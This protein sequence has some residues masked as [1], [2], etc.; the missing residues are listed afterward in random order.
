MLISPLPTRNFMHLRSFTSNYSVGTR[1]DYSSIEGGWSETGCRF[2]EK[3][4]SLYEMPPI[5]HLITGRRNSYPA[6]REALGV[7]ASLAVTEVAERFLERS[8]SS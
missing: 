7:H 5:E 1:T 6:T 2:F 8:V 4:E 3:H